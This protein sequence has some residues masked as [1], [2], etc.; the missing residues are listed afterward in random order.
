MI[1]K[2]NIISC[3]TMV[4]ERIYYMKVAGSLPQCKF[5]LGGV[6]PFLTEAI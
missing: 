1:F 3:G 4:E 5:F 6:A 2:A